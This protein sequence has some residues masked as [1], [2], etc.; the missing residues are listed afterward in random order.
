MQSEYGL[1]WLLKPQ[2][3]GFLLFC[4]LYVIYSVLHVVVCPVICLSCQQFALN[5][6]SLRCVE[7]VGAFFVT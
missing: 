1:L 5:S 7:F 3:E 4:L 2:L 6:V